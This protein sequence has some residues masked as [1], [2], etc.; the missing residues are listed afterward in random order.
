[1][2]TSSCAIEIVERDTGAVVKIIECPSAHQAERTDRGV[3]INLDHDKYFTR[4]VAT[5]ETP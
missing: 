3:Q 5:K 1:M 2:K 4:L